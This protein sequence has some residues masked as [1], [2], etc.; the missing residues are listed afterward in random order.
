MPLL[1]EAPMS[2]HA[3]WTAKGEPQYSVFFWG[4]S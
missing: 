2:V 3:D 1:V 4:Q